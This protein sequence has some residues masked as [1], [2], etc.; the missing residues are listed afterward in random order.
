MN[1]VVSSF[2]SQS[3]LES[4]SMSM[5]MIMPALLLQK[6]AKR[7]KTAQHVEA[8]KRRLPLWTEG[9]IDELLRE[10][11][12]IQQRIKRNKQSKEHIEQ[13]FVRLMFQGKVSAAMRWI[14]TSATGLLSALV[15][16]LK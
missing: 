7:S 2:V 6:P 3:S 15:P 10:G 5:L 4:V 1:K 16:Q 13:V 8:L 9:K 12:T 14:G 11:K